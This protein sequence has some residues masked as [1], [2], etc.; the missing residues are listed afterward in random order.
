MLRQFPEARIELGILAIRLDDPGLEIVDDPARGGSTEV[1]QRAAVRHRPVADLLVRHR[2]GVGQA[3]MRQ[4]RD[5]D[6]HVDR[7]GGG[8]QGQRL[9]GE[10]RHPVQSGRVVE[11][12]V[13]CAFGPA[14]R[15]LSSAQNRL[16]L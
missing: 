15:S 16:W 6:L 10:V 7:A 11:A 4:D 13:R 9:A 1:L 12:H 3:G 2:L 5:E 14:S 8:A